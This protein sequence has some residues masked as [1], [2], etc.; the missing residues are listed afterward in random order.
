MCG[1]LLKGHASDDLAKQCEARKT[2]GRVLTFERS[3][4]TLS[5]L[6]IVIGNTTP[7]MSGA[8]FTESEAGLDIPLTRRAV[9]D[10]DTPPGFR[11]SSKSN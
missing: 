4:R 5:P 11:V 2:K 7:F 10:A 3:P 6:I 9:T 8:N 1:S